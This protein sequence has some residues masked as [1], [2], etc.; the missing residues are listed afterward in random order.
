[1][2]TAGTQHAVVSH[3]PH[4]HSS[5]KSCPYSVFTTVLLPKHSHQFR[6]GPCSPAPSCRELAHYLTNALHRECSVASCASTS[7]MWAH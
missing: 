7:P 1:M 5:D 3:T 4:Q 6:R 2:Q